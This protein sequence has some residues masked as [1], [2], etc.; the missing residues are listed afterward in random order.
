MSTTDPTKRNQG[1]GDRRSARRYNQ[2]VRDHMRSGDP[3]AE[4]RDASRAVDAAPAAH[5]E[6]ERAGKERAAEFDPEVTMPSWWAERD[7]TTWNRIKSAF[8]RD[9]E[10]TKSDLTAGRAGHELDQHMADTIRQMSGS[11]PLPIEGE[12]TGVDLEVSRSPA[13]RAFELGYNAA[14]HFNGEWTPAV[15]SRL[16]TE[17]TQLSPGAF[18]D[19]HRAYVYLGWRHQRQMGEDA[20]PT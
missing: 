11:D 19:A 13:E 4:A 1:E 15:E 14:A 17:W 8:R 9:W 2:H 5:R 18:W 16:R 20:T 12:P 3:E 7:S 10:Q 6:A